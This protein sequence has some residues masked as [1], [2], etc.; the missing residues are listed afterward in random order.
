MF[1]RYSMRL[2]LL[3]VA[4]LVVSVSAAAAPVTIEF[5]SG[6]HGDDR[7]SM[8]RLVNLFNE[9]QDDV[10]VNWTTYQWDHM[11]SQLITGAAIGELP[12]VVAMWATV[13][14]EMVKSGVLTP[15][16][17]LATQYGINADDYVPRAWEAGSV[18]EILYGVPL[19]LH[20][21]ALFINVDHFT[22]AGLEPPAEIV[23]KEM[24]LDIAKR[25]TRNRDGQQQ[26]GFGLLPTTQWPV[27]Y[28]MALVAQQGGSML[29]DSLTRSTFNG[30][31]GIEA[32]NFLVS[33][34]ETHKVSPPNLG[35][36]NQGFLSGRV[37]MIVNGPWM[38]NSAIKQEGLNF[39]VIKFPQIYDKHATWGQSHVLV[40][41]NTRN[42]R[43]Q[44]A[45]MKFVKFLSDNSVQWAVGGQTPAKIEVI[46]SPE[47]QAL[48]EWRAF[49]DSMP[50]TVMNPFIPQQTKLFTHDPSSPFVYAWESVVQGTATVEEALSR[51]E[52]RVNQILDN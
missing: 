30:P 1:G 52:E 17:Q 42:T 6:F 24:F 47:I 13:V 34:I 8:E 23:G 44:E 51:A 36:L 27:R 28:W 50:T 21:L 43:N 5:W 9:S 11:N 14:P 4:I 48:V 46:N 16:D 41:P 32:M 3:I 2:G 39:K 29:D 33:L 19:D 45:A 26:W 10:F 37:S 20:Q 12:D 22:D 18:D 49:V 7:D 38:I 15:L 35:D 40:L 31:E 25:L